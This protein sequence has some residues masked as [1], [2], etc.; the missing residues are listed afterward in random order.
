MPAQTTA[1]IVMASAKRLIELRQVCLKSSRMAE[2]SVPA[3]PIPIHHTKL[4]MA[5][6]H[7]TG[8]V[9]PQMPV[10]R[11]NSH[12]TAISSRVAPPPARKRPPYHP[13]GVWGVRTMREIFSVTDLKVCPGPMTRISPVIGSSIGSLTGV[14]LVAIPFNLLVTSALRFGQ[15]R[16][17]VQYFSHI[18]RARTRV[19]AGQ[20]AVSPRLL[21]KLAHLARPVINIA[22]DDRIRRAGLLARRHNLAVADL[23]VFLVRV[24]L[25]PVNALH[26]VAALFHHAAAADSHVRVVHQLQALRLVIGEEQEV[27]AAHL[28]RAVVRAIAGTHAT[29]EDHR[30][31]A[32]RRVNRRT[33]WAN[34]LA[35]CVFAMLAGHRLEVRA[36]RGQIALKVGVDAQ[37]LHVAANLDLMLTD[38][39][40]VVLGITA[41]DAG[42]AAHAVFHV[43]RHPPCILVV[44]VGREHA[45]ILFRRFVPLAFVR[46]IRILLELFERGVADDAAVHRLIA[47]NRMRPATVAAMR[48]GTVVD[49]MALGDS[50]LNRFASFAEGC[51]RH[52]QRSIR[53]ADGI[54]IEALGAPYAA[55][56]AASLS[57][58]QCNC[59]IRMAGD[60]KDRRQDLQS[61]YAD[62]DNVMLGQ[63]VLVEC[64][65]TH[66][67]GIVPGK[68]RHRTRQLLQPANVGKTTV[69]QVIIRAENK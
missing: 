52:K 14:S 39:G 6:P 57:K 62:L 25:R 53:A 48:D 12:V 44:P 28:V 29:V 47:F 64:G 66:L 9:M 15:F 60:S 13:S 30:I 54:S 41:Y 21:L 18:G 35:G 63:P 61:V 8:C 40:D 22:E 38:D 50:K 46:E 42:V 2:I 51:T 58:R 68:V 5:K 69:V 59:V 34:L 65:I 56:A 4:M 49:V 1:K 31:E 27:E 45:L 24:D 33:D 7:A 26:A 3:W 10:P 32:F 43:D 67:R 19:V 20:H 36:R 11:R 16:V 55:C 37:P 17:Q 23:A